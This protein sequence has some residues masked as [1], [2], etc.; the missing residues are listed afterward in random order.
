MSPCICN[1]YLTKW[2]QKSPF[3]TF[4]FS[5]RFLSIKQ[6]RIA[7]HWVYIALLLVQCLSGL[8][9][10]L[11]RDHFSIYTVAWSPRLKTL[12]SLVFWNT[13]LFLCICHLTSRFSS[14]TDKFHISR[15]ELDQCGFSKLPKKIS[16]G[17]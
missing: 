9:E 2:R 14:V 13:I 16:A 17:L 4:F 10:P 5:V 11:R 8:I 7:V 3:I 15:T 12:P 6:D 1:F